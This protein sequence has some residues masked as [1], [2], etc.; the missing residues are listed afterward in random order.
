MAARLL[1]SDIA[2]E[3]RESELL[4][5]THSGRILVGGLFGVPKSG[6]KLRL[7]FDRRREERVRWSWLPAAAQLG[8][9]VLPKGK[10]LRGSGCDLID[11]YYHIAHDPNRSIHNAAGRELSED[12]V[13]KYG[14]DPCRIY[15]TCFRVLG[16]GD[17]NAVCFGQDILYTRTCSGRPML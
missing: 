8:R 4:P 7:V 2:F 16:M 10:V 11:Y 5:K 12:F 6:G 17:L 13:L 14:G 9:I 1:D 15:Y 3:E